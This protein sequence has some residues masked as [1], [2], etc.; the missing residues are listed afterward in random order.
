MSDTSRMS[1]G[2]CHSKKVVVSDVGSVH[3]RLT[4]LKSCSG[5]LDAEE[6][7]HSTAMCSINKVMPPKIYWL[8]VW[9]MFIFHNIW[10]NPS[11]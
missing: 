1:V 10:D 8:V 11:H 3:G 6:R 5:S 4:G 7:N 9:N 2:G